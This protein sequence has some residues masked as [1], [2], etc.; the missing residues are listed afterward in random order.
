VL[1]VNRGAG[2]AGPAIRINCAR[3]IATI[4]LV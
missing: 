3:E 1:Y 2:M 4:E